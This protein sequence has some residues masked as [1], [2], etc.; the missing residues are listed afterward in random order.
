[1]SYSAPVTGKSPFIPSV[2]NLR[3]AQTDGAVTRLPDFSSNIPNTL[4]LAATNVALPLL[5]SVGTSG[6]Y[7]RNTVTACA[8][9]LIAFDIIAIIG[10]GITVLGSLTAWRFP[11]PPPHQHDFLTHDLLLTGSIAVTILS[12]FMAKS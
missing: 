12:E 2:F 7:L 5:A 4:A 6:D 10:S 11:Y 3:Y 1:M 9:A 8:R